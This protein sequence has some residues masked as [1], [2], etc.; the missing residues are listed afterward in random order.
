MD[1]DF[2]SAYYSLRIMSQPE[3]S[4]MPIISMVVN[5]IAILAFAWQVFGSLSDIKSRIDLI[6]YRMQKL[7]ETK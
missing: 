7:E 4:K 2:L 6:D 3:N 1:W 5:W